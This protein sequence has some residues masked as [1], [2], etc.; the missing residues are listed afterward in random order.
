[1]RQ[2]RWLHSRQGRVEYDDAVTISTCVVVR[3]VVRPL[4]A[5]ARQVVAR[6]AGIALIGNAR[7][8][9]WHAATIGDGSDARAS[10]DYSLAVAT[11][12]SVDHC[13]QHALKCEW[14]EDSAFCTGAEDKWTPRA[15]DVAC[16]HLTV[17]VEQTVRC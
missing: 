16:E 4:W 13:G 12:V 11:K 14:A 3:C 5:D 7:C 9:R 8:A 17:V 1:M 2:K 15:L 6:R 10:G